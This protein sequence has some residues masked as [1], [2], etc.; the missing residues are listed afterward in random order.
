M[1][2]KLALVLSL[3][4]ALSAVA[5]NPNNEQKRAPSPTLLERGPPYPTGSGYDAVPLSSIVPLSPGKYAE[6]PSPA[7]P[8]PRSLLSSLPLVS[9]LS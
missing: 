1:S 5:H 7:P 6:S 8:L 4:L 3:H 9:T 2:Q